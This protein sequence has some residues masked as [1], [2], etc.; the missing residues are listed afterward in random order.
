MSGPGAEQE[1]GPGLIY[2]AGPSA[3]YKI[4][5]AVLLLIGSVP[6]LG[7]TALALLVPE[8]PTLL[9]AAAP[10]LPLAL[11]GGMPLPILR[12]AFT[13]TSWSV[14]LRGCFSTRSVDWP[15]VRVVEID[16]Y[17]L[18]RGGIVIVTRD[19]R[20]LKSALTHS[21]NTLYR[22]EPLTDHG[23]DLMHAAR[24]ARAAIETHRRWL[25]GTSDSPSRPT[26]SLHHHEV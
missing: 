9:L 16:R 12:P 22:G 11:F 25:H 5:V 21:H 24:P 10:L 18:N 8:R 2:R 4:M 17:W 6:L 15:G 7:W 3:L 1:S 20:R 14:E 13:V 23:P 26:G 19:G